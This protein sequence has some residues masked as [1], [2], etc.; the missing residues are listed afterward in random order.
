MKSWKWLLASALIAVGATV[1]GP[2]VSTTARVEAQTFRPIWH[3]EIQYYDLATNPP[4]LRRDRVGYF[5][6][7]F[8]ALEAYRTQAR[9]L[10]YFARPRIV[11]VFPNARP[12][13]LGQIA[14]LP[15]T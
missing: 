1:A 12:L 14:I 11:R 2:S 7:Y 5:T 8:E 3:Y 9:A 15:G 6:N 10:T 13:F 4:P